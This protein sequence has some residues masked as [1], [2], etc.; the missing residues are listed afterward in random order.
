MELLYNGN[1]GHLSL[2]D[3]TLRK[4][5]QIGIEI[6]LFIVDSHY[7]LKFVEKFQYFCTNN[8]IMKTYLLDI[9]GQILRVHIQGQT[10]YQH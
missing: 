3:T 6:Y 9:K 8:N 10:P 4:Q 1:S 2:A 5:L 7:S